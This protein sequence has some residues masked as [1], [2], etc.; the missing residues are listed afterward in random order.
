MEPNYEIFSNAWETLIF[1]V[2]EAL[3][4]MAITIYLETK[5]YNLL[6]THAEPQNLFFQGA[7]PG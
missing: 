1:L 3:I 2:I 5:K 7:N 4:Y 6:V